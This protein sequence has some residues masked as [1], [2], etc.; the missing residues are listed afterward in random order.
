MP[1]QPGEPVPL[2]HPDIPEPSQIP[3]GIPPWLIVGCAILVLIL[4]ALILWM[5]FRPKSPPK[6]APRDAL[7]SALRSLKSLRSKAGD[8]PPPEVGRQVSETLRRYF[9]ERY[10]VPAPC[11]TTPELFADGMPDKLRHK[12]APVA[13]KYDAMAFAPQAPATA[14]ALSL[15][16]TAIQKLEEERS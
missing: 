13:H 3:A 6:P 8:L 1:Q 7:K 4:A 9:Q 2:P 16:E 5:L 15:I 10:A 12:F 14:E 11:R